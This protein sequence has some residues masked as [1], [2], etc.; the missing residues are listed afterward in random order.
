M[1]HFHVPVLNCKVHVLSMSLYSLE[2][3]QI[4]MS[5]EICGENGHVLARDFCMKMML[6][7]IFV[8]ITF[9]QILKC[10]NE[11]AN[12]YIKQ[13]YKDSIFSPYNNEIHYA[14]WSRRRKTITCCSYVDVPEMH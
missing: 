4:E 12:V 11:N 3:C 13:Q 8:C 1:V 14:Q 10:E 7:L 9:M 6:R 2:P 5:N